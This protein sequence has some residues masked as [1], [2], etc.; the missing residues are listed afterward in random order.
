MRK[1]ITS[2]EE[3]SAPSDA[4]FQAALRAIPG[5]TDLDATA[6][7]HYAAG[8]QA[9][10]DSAFPTD[11]CSC[12]GYTEDRGGGYS[13]YMLE[14]DPACP[15]H[16]EHVW[17]PRK[18][19]WTHAT[20]PAPTTLPSVE[21]VAQA[22]AATYGAESHTE[23]FV[24]ALDLNA[25]RAVLALLPGRSEQAVKAEAIRWVAG[26]LR[27]L[28]EKQSPSAP[29]KVSVADVLEGYAMAIEA[30]DPS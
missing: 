10:T 15:E 29:I 26:E 1:N 6:R 17:N 18:Q 12:T 16:S 13:E 14:Y 21:A 28:T 3:E 11:G 24:G 22:L 20:E 25:A 8:W 19:M 9:G 5:D 4:A 27:E 30:G 23:A 7:G 2:A